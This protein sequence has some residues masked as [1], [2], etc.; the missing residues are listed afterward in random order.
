[1]CIAV[2]FGVVCRT[3]VFGAVVFGAIVFA[4]VCVELQSCGVW[5]DSRAWMGALQLDRL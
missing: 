1:M 5:G 2:I 3:V 4:A